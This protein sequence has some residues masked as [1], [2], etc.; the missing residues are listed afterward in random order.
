MLIVFLAGSLQTDNS[1]CKQLGGGAAIGS[2][3]P[4]QQQPS[5][6]ATMVHQPLVP[7]TCSNVGDV[8]FL[9]QQCAFCGTVPKQLQLVEG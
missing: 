1:A 5:R 2:R 9:E 7:F 6:M 8:A 3:L 4:A